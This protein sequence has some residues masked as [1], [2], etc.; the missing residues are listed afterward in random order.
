LPGFAQAFQLKS[1]P[2][3]AL[4]TGAGE[5][6]QVANRFG[7]FGE[8]M[9]THLN[10]T[11]VPE[12]RGPMNVEAGGPYFG[13][14]VSTNATNIVGESARF[15]NAVPGQPQWTIADANTIFNL[16]FIQTLLAG[17]AI[18]NFAGAYD[19]TAQVPDVGLRI[20]MDSDRHERVLHFTAPPYYDATVPMFDFYGARN[21]T[22]LEGF[23]DGNAGDTFFAYDHAARVLAVTN[24][25]N[26][27]ARAIAESKVMLNSNMWNTAPSKDF[28]EPSFHGAGLSDGFQNVSEQMLVL[29]HEGNRLDGKH[30]VQF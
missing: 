14:N 5:F 7:R 4:L 17:G 20:V 19:A 11:S 3:A 26:D 27:A 2:T 6:T 13:V 21:P 10:S 12:M 8:D 22:S 1:Q 16:A 24:A 23:M 29:A 30:P 28:F 25:A 18:G 15:T 9:V